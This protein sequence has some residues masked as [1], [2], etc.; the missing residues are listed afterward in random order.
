M[1]FNLVLIR[2]SEMAV[3]VCFQNNAVRYYIRRFTLQNGFSEMD[4]FTTFKSDR[5]MS[6]SYQSVPQA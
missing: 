2:V 6:E 1:F 5:G 3:P 4:Q